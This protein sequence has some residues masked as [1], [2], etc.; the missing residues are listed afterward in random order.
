MSETATSPLPVAQERSLPPVAWL[1]T[2]ALGLVIVGGILMAAYA[3]RKA[4]LGIATVLA[5]GGVLLELASVTL[6]SRIRDFS[7]ATFAKV[8]KWMLL[9]YV[10]I[11]GMIE[12]AFVHDH[13][14]GASL[15]IVTVML[16]VFACSVPT[17]SAFTVARYAE[18]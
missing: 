17:I 16:V 15:G 11:S 3:P 4:P 18:Q 12:F 6:L 5:I 2:V 7:W 14:R 9:V 1:S 10:I 8:F 13:T